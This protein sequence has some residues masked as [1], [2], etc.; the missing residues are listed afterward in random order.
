MLFRSTTPPEQRC[1]CCC[2]AAKQRPAC[3]RRHYNLQTW[4]SSA[5]GP[6][7]ATSGHIREV[8]DRKRTAQTF[9]LVVVRAQVKAHPVGYHGLSR[10]ARW[11]LM[12]APPKNN[13]R[14]LKWPSSSRTIFF[15]SLNTRHL[16]P[17]APPASK[18]RSDEQK[19]HDLIAQPKPLPG[20]RRH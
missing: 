20:P 17:R 15:F 1:A 10:S 3:Q 16:Q 14:R 7:R 18:S 12:E 5:S 19:I 9:G 6:V 13:E 2:A 8:G 4:P 11:A